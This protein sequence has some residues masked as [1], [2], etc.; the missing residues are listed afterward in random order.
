MKKILII[1]QYSGNKGDRAVLFAMVSELLKQDVQ[2]VVS[3]H[4]PELW[5]DYSFYD[6][7]NIKFI[8]WGWDF[9]THLH[10]KSYWNLLQIIKKYT[11]T[12][13]RELFL[14]PLTTPM[15]LL[16]LFMHPEFYLGLKDADLV[17]STGGHHITT[18]LS[19]DAISS[20]IYDLALAV[21]SGKDVIVWSQT[22]GPLKFFNNRNEKFMNKLLSNVSEIFIRDQN[23][24]DYLQNHLTKI[25]HTYE[26]VFVLNSLFDSYILPSERENRLGIAIYSTKQRNEHEKEIYINTL[27]NLANFVIA[28]GTEIRFFPMEIKNTQPDDRKMIK[29]I[30]NKINDKHLC[31]IIDEDLETDAH[32]KEVAKCRYFLGHKTH[33]IVFALTTGTP[34]IALAY[35]P[36][37]ADFMHQFSLDNYVIND[38][39]LSSERLNECFEMLMKDM[40]SIGIAQFAK[41]REMSKHVSHDLTSLVIS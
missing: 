6:K 11:Y 13:V 9:Q 34:L 7:N 14:L 15:F 5:H 39:E 19:R 3:T 28:Q 30:V 18:I 37:S 2:I 40:D 22:I 32:L 21:S 4:S 36:K 38:E 25:K 26:S 1:N 20:Q 35:H 17:I 10:E 8:P 16:R 27:A 31:T 41:S 23:S 12:I 24:L 33:S 29:E